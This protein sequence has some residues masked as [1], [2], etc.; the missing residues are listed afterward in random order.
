MKLRISLAL[1]VIYS[2]MSATAVIAAS[3]K[4][5]HDTEYY[6]LEAQN[7]EKWAA[8]DKAVDLKL[9]DFKKKNNGKPPNILYILIDDIGFGDLGNAELNAIRGYKT[10][11]IKYTGFQVYRVLDLLRQIP[12]YTVSFTTR[13]RAAST[14][15]SLTGSVCTSTNVAKELYWL[16]FS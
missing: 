16:S 4:I 2:L 7:G 8:D 3:E 12:L 5:V 10:P 14:S 6:I 13:V 9:A 11:N 1:L 15:A